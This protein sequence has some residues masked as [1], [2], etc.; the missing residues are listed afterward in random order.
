MNK[1]LKQVINISYDFEAKEFIA[2]GTNALSKLL[3]KKVGLV[4]SG[5]TLNELFCSIQDNIEELL[6]DD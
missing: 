6:K 3:G 2:V 1:D 4:V 5:Y